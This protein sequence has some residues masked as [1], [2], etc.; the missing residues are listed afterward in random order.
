MTDHGSREPLGDKYNFLFPE[1]R[2]WKGR[3][4][5]EGSQPGPLIVWLCVE[6]ESD[7]G[8]S[9]YADENR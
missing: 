7:E 2:W 9:D 5:G 3:G 1:R 6:D 4:G 8:V